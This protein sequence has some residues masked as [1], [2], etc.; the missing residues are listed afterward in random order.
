MTKP[1]EP[2]YAE[3]AAEMADSAKQAAMDTAQKAK[4]AITGGP[5]NE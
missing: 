1:K 2:T 5:K 4:D 3:K